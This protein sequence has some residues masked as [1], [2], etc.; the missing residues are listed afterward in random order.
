[1]ADVANDSLVLH[2]RHVIQSQHIYIAGAGHVDVAAAQSVFDGGNFKT[3]HR[4]LQGID[5]IDLGNHN[6]GTHAAQGV[7][8]PLAYVAVAADD[9]HLAGYHDIGCPLDAVRQ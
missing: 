5:R 4:R 3:F 1:M 7:S 8:R 2:F 6:P 9:S